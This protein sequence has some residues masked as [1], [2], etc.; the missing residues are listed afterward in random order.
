MKII[1]TYIKH[2]FASHVSQ[3]A[4]ANLYIKIKNVR[5][6]RLYKI[7]ALCA[8]IQIGLHSVYFIISHLL[9]FVTTDIEKIKIVGAS[10]CIRNN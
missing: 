9:V 6:L 1:Q 7:N 10:W 4:K 5:H 2:E 3:R 8:D